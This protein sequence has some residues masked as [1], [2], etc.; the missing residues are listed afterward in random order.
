MV[1]FCPFASCYTRHQQWING[2][3]ISGTMFTPSAEFGDAGDWSHTLCVD[4][5]ENRVGRVV[6]SFWTANRIGWKT[7]SVEDL[8]AIPEDR[9][10]AGV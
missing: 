6:I 4:R 8:Q 1:F 9:M 7:R 5:W 2:F 10:S 3:N